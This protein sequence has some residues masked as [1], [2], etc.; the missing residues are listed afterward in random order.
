MQPDRDTVIRQ[1]LY[2][3]GQASIQELAEVAQASLA[4]IRRDLLRL[5]DKGMVERTHGGARIAG[6]V[7]LEVAFEAREL[8]NIAAKKAIAQAAYS[9]LQPGMSVMLDAGST[10]LQL[11]RLLRVAPLP[12]T[13]F[14]NSLVVVQTLN[15]VEDLRLTLLGGQ[16]RPENHSVV[17]PIAEA[18]IDRLW[19]D[20]LFLGA[21]A[22]QDDGTLSTPDA[23]E[24]SINLRMLQRATRRCILADATKF[25][26]TATYGVAKLEAATDVI[27]DAALDARWRARLTDCG[28][29]VT[30]ADA[31]PDEAAHA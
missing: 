23:A 15:G 6:K 9:R 22:V 29:A 16:V 14:T 21:S 4:T 13:V 19:F 30:I 5:E 20:Q 1:H 7:G 27:S 8:Q 31:S 11:A 12:L 17:G 26:Q 24:A 2:T 28:L 3:K 18:T 25:G 10:V